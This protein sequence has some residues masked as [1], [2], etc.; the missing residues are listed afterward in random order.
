MSTIIAISSAS[1]RRVAAVDE[2]IAARHEPIPF[3]TPTM[4]AT[5]FSSVTARSIIGSSRRPCWEAVS[6]CTRVI[7]SRVTVDGGSHWAPVSH[8][9]AALRHSL[10]LPGP[11]FDL[12]PPIGQDRRDGTEAPIG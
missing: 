5:L 11:R 4:T 6:Q 8:P 2:Q 7:R 1:Y 3:A 10:F 9:A 12:S